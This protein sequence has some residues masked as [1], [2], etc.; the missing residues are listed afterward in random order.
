MDVSDQQRRVTL[1]MVIGRYVLVRWRSIGAAALIGIVVTILSISALGVFAVLPRVIIENLGHASML[2]VAAS[3]TAAFDLR[4]IMAIAAAWTNAM[5]GT[6]S[7][8]AVVIV[9]LVI[10]TLMTA[11]VRLLQLWSDTMGHR[12]RCD[13]AK[14]FAGDVFRHV[15]NQSLTFFHR[16]RVGDLATRVNGDSAAFSHAAFEVVHMAVSAVPLAL[17]YWTVMV[18]TSWRLTLVAV[19]VFG[20]KA[21]LTDAMSRQ[22]AK[23]V[24]SLAKA[25]G[26][27]AGWV[28]EVFN[29]IALVK[30]SGNESR[31]R[32]AFQNL[33]AVQLDQNRQQLKLGQISHTGQTILQ[34]IAVAVV[35]GLGSTMLL[36]GTIDVATLLA[37]VFV[38]NRAQEPTRRLLDFVQTFHRARAMAH[39]LLDILS[40]QPS[41]ED[42]TQE[43]QSFR[44]TLRIENASFSFVPNTPVVTGLDLA[45]EKG[46][47]VALVGRSGAGKSTILNLLL[48]FYDPQTGRVTLDGVDIRGFTQAS[49]RR[50]FAVVTQEPQL[51]HISLRDNILYGLPN[52][53]VDEEAFDY[54]VRASHV[55]EFAGALEHG[56]DTVIGDRGV[57]LSGGQRQRIALARAILR[58]AP[59]LLLDEATSSLDGHSEQLIQD[60]ISHFLV[61]R[62][63]VIVAHRLSTIRRA[64]R[65]LVIEGGVIVE[66]GTHDDLIARQ[67]AYFHLYRTQ[68]VND[69]QAMAVD[70]GSV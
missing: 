3:D 15:T 59:I 28:T 16:H 17:F 14:V 41:I 30:V 63:A 34:T 33:F 55:D 57:R 10:Y 32:T 23:L 67:G 69:S 40:E 11:T 18:V 53:R 36:S 70:H 65:I 54:A 66:S 8:T 37:Y 7:P 20:L 5:F 61:D 4:T 26:L 44:H 56:Y 21:L 2:D 48:R 35:V 13:V 58:N 25:R 9:L 51:F 46:Q 60:A 1:S 39:R 50:L 12:T 29:N 19:V 6:A 52:D 38:A 31:V 62:T 64:D 45:V 42:G 24:A 49:Y 43:A 47:V 22:I 27:A 68:F